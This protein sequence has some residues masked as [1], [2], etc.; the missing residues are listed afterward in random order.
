MIT[1]FGCAKTATPKRPPP[2]VTVTQ[3][4]LCDAPIYRDYVGHVTPFLSVQVKAQVSGII[5]GQYFTE[6]KEAKQGDLLL[7]IDDRPYL[8]SLAKSEATLAQNLAS[9]KYSEE[10]AH[11]YA[12]LLQDDYVSKLDYDQYL[13]NVKVDES[14]IKE[15][16]A[17]VQTAKINLDYC[18]IRAPMDCVLGQLQVKPGNYVNVSENT[19]LILLNQINPIKVSFYVPDNDLP[20]IRAHQ[21][22]TPLKVQ[23]F[24]NK[25]GNLPSE[26]TLTLID[27]Q[28]QE[29]TGTILLEATLPNEDKFLW[30]G[31]FVDIRLI[32]ETQKEALL[33]P[34]EAVQSSEKG[35]FVFVVKRDQTIEMRPITLQQ[36]QERYTLVQKGLSPEDIVVVEGQIGIY[37]GETVVTQK[38]RG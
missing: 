11:R 2:L 16:L 20:E 30:P 28:I 36:R 6:G 35:P 10:T 24:W 26:G 34:N 12:G 23:V 9:L 29:N 4:I 17:D 33:I 1:F 25:D 8:A 7:T 38:A 14:I 18:F 22:Q 15:N 19:N 31:A 21:K 32:L 27:N 5:T 13:T 37:P 3:P